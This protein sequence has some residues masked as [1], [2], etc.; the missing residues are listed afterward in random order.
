LHHVITNRRFY[1]K[2]GKENT[3]PADGAGEK[4][5]EPE[6][7]EPPRKRFK[8]FSQEEEYKDFCVVKK[9]Y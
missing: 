3:I 6:V 1:F 7:P 9:A 5:G 8:I 2:V 4:E